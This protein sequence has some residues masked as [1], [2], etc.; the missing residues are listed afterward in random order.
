M[1]KKEFW[2]V[3]TFMLLI[4]L[5]AVIYLKAMANTGVIK[6]EEAGYKVAYVINSNPDVKEKV[7]LVNVSKD[8][9]LYRVDLRQREKEFFVYSSLDGKYLVNPVPLEHVENILN[10]SRF[11]RTQTLCL[12]SRESTRN[13]VLDI[14]K[15]SKADRPRIELFVM[16]YDSGALKVMR[17]ILPVVKNFGGKIDFEVK[18]LD[19]ALHGEKEIREELQQYCIESEQKEKYLSYLECFLKNMGSNE[20][21]TVAKVDKTKLTLCVKE[22]DLKFRITEKYNNH[23]LWGGERIPLD[24]FVEDNKKYGVS[25]SPT[26]VI[27]GNLAKIEKFSEEICEA[28]KIIPEECLREGKKV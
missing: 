10:T 4:F 12:S 11:L 6:A 15:I 19:Y 26:L 20:C 7:E 24:I 27:N 14:S 8:G 17:D 13:L 22:T 2:M 5:V 23:S 3:F 28:F 16:S 18:F 1:L 9:Q 21:L 25:E